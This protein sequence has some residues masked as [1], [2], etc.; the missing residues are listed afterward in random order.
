[1]CPGVDY[2]DLVLGGTSNVARC[3][4]GC[5]KCLTPVDLVAAVLGVSPRA[6]VDWISDRFGL[7]GFPRGHAL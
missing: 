5:E 4:G 1:L 2:R 3:F 7:V 6:A